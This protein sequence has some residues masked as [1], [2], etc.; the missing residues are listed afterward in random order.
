[1]VE[2]YDGTKDYMWMTMT[3]E[4]L[5]PPPYICGDADGSEAVDIDDVVFLI[6]YIFAGGVPPDPIEAG[7]ADCSGG[8]DIDDAVWL[9]NFIFAGGNVP[10]D[11]DGDEAPDC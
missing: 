9:I 2:D 5:P 11:V 1:M 4:V 3:V 10:C 7:D 8:V 6:N